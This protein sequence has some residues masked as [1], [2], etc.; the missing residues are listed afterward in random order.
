MDSL[1][2]QNLWPTTPGGGSSLWPPSPVSPD[3]NLCHTSELV[4]LQSRP[5]YL[6][7]A[8]PWA[9]LLLCKWGLSRGEKKALSV[10]TTLTRIL[11]SSNSTWI[12]QEM[13][14]FPFQQYTICLDW[15]LRIEEAPSSWPHMYSGTFIKLSLVEGKK[16]AVI[17][18][19][20]QILFLL[21]FSRFSWINISLFAA[22]LQAN[23]QIYL[24]LIFI[25]Y[26]CFTRE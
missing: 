3:I 10:S 12:R 8:M 15:E 21:S 13:L 11:A 4:W 6:Y 24:T 25:S 23:F 1:P 20:P 22:C 16:E 14:S 26:A 18:E 5:Q 19:V 2:R 9:E 7:P 17:D